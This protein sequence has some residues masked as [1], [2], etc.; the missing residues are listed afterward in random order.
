MEA[1]EKEKAAKD[2]KP[3]KKEKAKVKEEEK[4]A[5]QQRTTAYTMMVSLIPLLVI[6]PISMT[7]V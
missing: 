5:R 3:V 6:C 7:L 2:Q 1:K 4:E